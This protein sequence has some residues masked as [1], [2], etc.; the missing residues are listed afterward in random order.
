MFTTPTAINPKMITIAREARFLTQAQ[1]AEQLGCLQGTL[2]KVENGTL[3]ATEN[4]LEQLAKVL[5]Y[6]TSFFYQKEEPLPPALFYYRKKSKATK[7]ESKKMEALMNIF[8]F[9]LEKL[10]TSIDI[11]DRNYQLWDVNTHG[12]PSECAKYIRD[13]WRL[14]KGK[15]NNLTEIAEN[16]GI[17]VIYLKDLSLHIDGLS[18]PVRSGNP[19]IFINGSMPADRTKATLAHEI[20]HLLLHHGQFIAP[21]RDVESEAW[22]FAGE[23]LLPENEIKPFV[24]RLSIERLAELKMQWKVSMQM[25][26][27]RAEK[28]GTITNSQYRLLITQMN[29]YGYKVNE[30]QYFSKEIPTLISEV[31]ESHLNDLNYTMD[32]LSEIL[33]LHESEIRDFYLNMEERPSLRITR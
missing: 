27:Y 7:V 15:I 26:L 21:D 3:S 19:I 2:S 23:L 10:L 1:L 13:I 12:S 33:C 8:R 16:N 18:M 9:N 5:K 30:P 25:I 29:K 31:V 20:G 14:P 32:E 6:P 24:R 11:P 17:I 4:F 22:E 28:L